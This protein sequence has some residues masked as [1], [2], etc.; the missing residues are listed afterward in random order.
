MLS[1]PVQPWREFMQG[2]PGCN[3]RRG[4]AA[5]MPEKSDADLSSVVIAQKLRRA[6]HAS[7]LLHVATGRVPISSCENVID[8]REFLGREGG[9]LQRSNILINLTYL[10]RTDQRRRDGRIV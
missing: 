10:A 4:P 1:A 9:V 2:S 8:L 5:A 6:N 7:G 3:C